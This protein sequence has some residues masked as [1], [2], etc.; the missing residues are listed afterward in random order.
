MKTRH[1][2]IFIGF[3]L[4]LASCGSEIDGDSGDNGLPEKGN[5]IYNSDVVYYDK[6]GGDE[7]HQESFQGYMVYDG[8]KKSLAFKPYD[9]SD[10]QITLQNSLQLGTDSV[11]WQIDNQIVSLGGEDFTLEGLDVFSI[12][13]QEYHLL[14]TQDSIFVKY[15]SYLLDNASPVNYTTASVKGEEF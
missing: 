13:G 3:L 2:Y 1:L 7:V 9:G 11:A 6:P 10:W 5:F 12:N 15:R 8:N 14:K 4:A